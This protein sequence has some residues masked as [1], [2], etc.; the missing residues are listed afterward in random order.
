MCIQSEGPNRGASF[1]LELPLSAAISASAVQHS[2]PVSSPGMGSMSMKGMDCH[3]SS[4]VNDSERIHEMNE[5]KGG[6]RRTVGGGSTRE[7]LSDFSDK[8]VVVPSSPSLPSL[9]EVAN[10]EE[11]EHVID[12]PDK[13]KDKDKDKDKGL[14]H[15]NKKKGS[16]DDLMNQLTRAQKD[17]KDDQKY[18]VAVLAEAHVLVVE[19][20][21][22]ARKVYIDKGS[23]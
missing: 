16:D 9:L 11:R 7:Y 14:V 17:K 6:G 2:I 21:A 22:A 1:V 8:M 15:N 23:S 18:D 4:L 5:S 19:D 3:R 10:E 12:P 13:G 20:S